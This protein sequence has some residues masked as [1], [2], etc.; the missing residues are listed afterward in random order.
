MQATSPPSR[1]AGSAGRRGAGL[2][3]RP[4]HWAWLVLVSSAV[5]IAVGVVLAVWWWQTAESEGAAYRVP[6]P[7]ARVEITVEAGDVDVLGGGPLQVTVRRDE[8][9]VY[10]QRPTEVRSF[11][12]GVLHVRSTCP[13]IVLGACSADY[14][15][16]VPEDVPVIVRSGSGDI[17]LT[18]YRGEGQ[19]ETVSGDVVVD[20]Y[21]GPALAVGSDS[22]S[23][24]VSAAC[25]PQRLE[26]AS[27]DGDVTAAVP[28]GRYRV[29]AESGSGEVR[30]A[31]LTVVDDAESEIQALSANGDVT[32]EGSE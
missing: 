17:R 24:R 32:V 18:S 13:P 12:D 2:R 19:V 7:V 1:D 6:S 22:G 10:D 31:G 5:L 8:R 25:A 9:F 29:D 27:R 11:E 14:R 23:V 28:A 21:C 30:I 15:L 20:A 16:T 3:T 26:L 4:S